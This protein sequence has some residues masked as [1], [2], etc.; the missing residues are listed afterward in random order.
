MRK[1]T[2]QRKNYLL[3][4]NSVFDEPEGDENMSQF[5]N[6]GL[7][8]ILRLNHSIYLMPCSFHLLIETLDTFLPLSEIS[9]VE[10]K[11][12]VILFFTLYRQTGAR[13]PNC[14]FTNSSILVFITRLMQSRYQFFISF[15]NSELNQIHYS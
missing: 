3:F 13:I 5:L 6:V 8:L 4:R 10:T 12:N 15:E 7:T 11:N 2:L 1:K 14:C 9:C